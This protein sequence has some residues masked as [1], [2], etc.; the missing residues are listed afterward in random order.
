MDLFER[1]ERLM[2]MTDAVWARHASPWSVYTRFTML[3]LFALAVWA[4]TWVGGWSWA[5]VALVLVWVWL[6]PRVFP[7]PRYTDTWA[8]KGTFGERVFLNRKTI[9]IPDHHLRWGLGLGCLSALGLPPFAYG[10]WAFDLWAT[11]LGMVLIV[12]PKVW[13]VDRMV[14]LYDD[15]KDASPAY[16]RWLRE[17]PA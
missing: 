2:G 9:P 15:M 13:F 5:L 6:N 16:R 4:R 3:P 7:V 12:L 14:W 10:L 8:A 1:A 11:L 17:R